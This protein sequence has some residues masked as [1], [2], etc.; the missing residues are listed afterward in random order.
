MFSDTGYAV[1]VLWDIAPRRFR[2]W[3]V[4]VESP[5]RRTSFGFDTFDQ[6]LHIV[7][8]PDLTWRWKDVENL[9]ALVEAGMFSTAEK[10]SIWGWGRQAAS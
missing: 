5:Y 2:N 8:D 1:Y 6:E 10:E 3:Y 7:V 4:N 9:D